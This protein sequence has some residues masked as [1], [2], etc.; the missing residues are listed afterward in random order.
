VRHYISLQFAAPIPP[1]NALTLVT[2]IRFT[3][4]NLSLDI[5]SAN[6][7]FTSMNYAVARNRHSTDC[8]GFNE[9]Y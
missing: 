3:T 9:S 8:E 7:E 4:L 1:G 6:H 5:I 2:G